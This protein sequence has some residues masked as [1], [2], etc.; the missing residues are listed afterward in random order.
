MWPE[1]QERNRDRAV[2]I[3]AQAILAQVTCRLSP[4]GRLALG[5]GPL[6]VRRS[7]LAPGGGRVPE[8]GGLESHVKPFFHS[9][10]L[11]HT[12]LRGSKL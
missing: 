2:A 8:R 6:G 1:G 12:P 7:L 9:D 11:L 5:T 3:L 10:P 4:L